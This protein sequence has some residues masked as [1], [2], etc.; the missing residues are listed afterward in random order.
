MMDLGPLFSTFG[1][2]F[3]AELGDKTQLAVVAQT[4]RYRRPWTVFA[5]ASAALAAATALGVAGGQ[6]LGRAV[7]PSILQAAAALGFVV[8]GLL[9]AREAWK[10]RR[11]DSSAVCLDGPEESACRWDWGAFL[12]TFGLLFVA[13]LGDKT[14]LAVLALSGRSGS[15]WAVFCGG[16]LALVVVTA[17]GVVGGDRLIR[18]VPE[19]VLLA[20]SAVA[21]VAMGILIGVGIG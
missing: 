6:V 4:C 19:R 8:M 13:E 15:P 11:G 12:S 20:A 17:L 9:M 16:T 2:V 10:S 1:L 3:L 5:G 7:P 14:Q 21:F 18:F